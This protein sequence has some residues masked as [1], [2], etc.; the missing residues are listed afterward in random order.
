MKHI[1]KLYKS[2]EKPESKRTDRVDRKASGPIALCTNQVK[3]NAENMGT[4]YYT[5]KQGNELRK[6]VLRT[7]PPV[8]SVPLAPARNR[9]KQKRSHE[10]TTKVSFP[11]LV[12][13]T[14][15]PPPLPLPVLRANKDSCRS[16]GVPVD[17]ITVTF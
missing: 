17:T 14:T 12:S 15:K 2:L 5:D 1:A 13:S 8:S 11:P 6:Q 9:K 16:E 4:V 10:V 7:P 3:D